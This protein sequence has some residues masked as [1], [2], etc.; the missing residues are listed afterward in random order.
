METSLD[1]R[2]W[3]SY[4]STAFFTSRSFDAV[5]LIPDLVTPPK[6]NRCW[7]NFPTMLASTHLYCSYNNIAGLHHVVASASGVTSIRR[8]GITASSTNSCSSSRPSWTFAILKTFNCRT[9]CLLA[10]A[11][12]SIHQVGAIQ[13]ET[14][15]ITW[16]WYCSVYVKQITQVAILSSCCFSSLDVSVPDGEMEV[17]C[18]LVRPMVSVLVG[19]HWSGF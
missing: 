19:H 12:Y 4:V 17:F 7:F 11:S 5:K 1:C 18:C 15:Y 10:L 14:I 6:R 2:L 9:L 8:H 3:Q 13:L 16:C